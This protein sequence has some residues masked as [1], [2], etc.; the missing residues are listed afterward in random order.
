[1]FWLTAL[2]FVG[3]LLVLVLVHEWGH[4]LAA[5]WAGCRVEE[6][7]FGFPPRV[8]SWKYHDT[9]YSLNLFPLGGFVKIEGEDMQEAQPGPH[10]FASK[11]AHWRIV[12]LA[13]GVVMNVLLAI[14]LLSV[15]AGLGVPRVATPENMGRLADITTYVTGVTPNSPAAQA[16]LRELDRIVRV[17][18]ISQ[19]TLEQ[20]QSHVATQAGQE[21]TLEVVHDGQGREVVI[22]PR[23]HPPANEGPLGVEL[24]AT[25]L[26]RVPWWRAPLVGITRTGQM[27]QA[28]LGQFWTILGRLMQSGTLG[29]AVAGPIGIAVYTGEAAQL[30]L[31][32]VLEF[33]ALIS[34]NLALINILPFPALDGGRIVFVLLEKLRGRPLAA[35]IEQVTH[36][37]G[38][39][40]LIGLMI[41][42]TWRDIQ[43]FF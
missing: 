23:S 20:L 38:F 7:G 26:E 19:P 33:G 3:L 30:G 17:D 31:P 12:I 13:A 18:T 8:L 35:R 39:A 14:V 11:P 6:F 37:I 21:I 41:V 5:R 43:R 1:M 28:I 25:G 4:F 2:I 27:L 15:Q 36:A 9:L 42:I 32:Y 34:L 29:D 22:T 24:M 40:V 10:S 16:G